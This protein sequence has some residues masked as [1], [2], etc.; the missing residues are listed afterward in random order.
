MS[1]RRSCRAFLAEPLPRQV[2]EEILDVAG[3]S[4]SWCN[5]QPWQVVVAEGAATSAFQTALA[6]HMA[7]SPPLMPDF[8]FPER[9]PGVYDTRRKGAGWQ[10][11][12]SVGIARGDRVGSARQAARNYEFFDAPHVAVITTEADLGVYGVL[13]CGVYLSAFLLAAESLGVGAIAQASLACYPTVVREQFD[14]PPS[15][16]VV[17]GISFGWPDR[18]HPANGFRTPRADMA[19]IVTWAN[20]QSDHVTG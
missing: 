15:R 16:L 5:T 17:C 19:D 11:Y 4:P 12:E 7:E 10:L 20:A 1:E 14:L 18:S 13:D 6:D 2:I 8:P 9:Y 3:R